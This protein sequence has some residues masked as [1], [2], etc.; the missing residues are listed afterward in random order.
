MTE[1]E[2][3]VPQNDERE[4]I[5]SWI[6]QLVRRELTGALQEAEKTLQP[7]TIHVDDA[8]AEVISLALKIKAGGEGPGQEG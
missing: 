3:L 1:A 2:L 8:A 7:L 4:L 6:L 5:Q